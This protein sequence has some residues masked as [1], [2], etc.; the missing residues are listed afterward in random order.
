MAL[1]IG[2]VL[3]VTF[4][5]SFSGYYSCVNVF[6]AAAVGDSSRAMDEYAKGQYINSL[7]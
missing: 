6:P 4:K 7:H 3:L 5:V 1:W 2:A